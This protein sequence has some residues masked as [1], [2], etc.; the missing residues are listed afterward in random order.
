MS[1]N[2]IVIDWLFKDYEYMFAFCDGVLNIKISYN[3][4][5]KLYDV[6]HSDVPRIIGGYENNEINVLSLY[7][8]LNL[9]FGDKKKV[10][11]CSSTFYRAKKVFNAVCDTFNESNLPDFKQNS[12]SFRRT[13]CC[14]FESGGNSVVF[15]PMGDG[16]KM[17]GVRCLILGDGFNGLNTKIFEDIVSGYMAINTHPLKS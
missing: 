6:W 1:T 9:L 11:I 2:D 15:A 7:S 8:V 12:G 3:D 10:V 16:Q 4:Y 17:R 13:D 5:C 14:G